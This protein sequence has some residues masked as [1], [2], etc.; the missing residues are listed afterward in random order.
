MCGRKTALFL[1]FLSIF[2]LTNV[3]I[4]FVSCSSN[5]DHSSEHLIDVPFHYQ[6]IEY[7]CGPAALQMVFDYYGEA[8]N[9][10]EIADVAR[11]IG[12]PV[13]STFTDELRRAAH[14]SNVST[15]M[16]VEIPEENIT[17]YT[18]RKLGYA[19]FEA[20]DMNLTQL[21]SFI[22][23]DK[24]LILLMWYSSY[25][26]SIHYRVATGYN[27]TH[28]FLHDPWNKLSWGGTYG[29]PNIA[30]NNTQFLD[31]WSYY[32]YW[33]LYV[34]PWT[35]NISAPEFIKLDSPF[36]INT[37]ITYP[38]SLPNTLSGYS[39]SSCN[40][41][42]TLP[43]NLS[44]APDETQRKTV[45]T[46][47]LEA[48]SNAT[49]SWMLTANSSITNTVIV[50]V[51]GMI[52]GSVWAHVNYSAYDYYDRI[53]VAI[54]ITI[55]LKEDSNSPLIGTPSRVPE[56]DVSPDQEA[57]VLVNVT[58]VESGVE[59]VTLFYNLNDSV[60]WTPLSMDFNSTSS[61]YEATIPKQPAGTWVK[62][63]I[64]AYDKVGNFEEQNNNNDYFI[65]KVVPE[66]TS[67]TIILFLVIL[68]MIAAALSR[69]LSKTKLT[70]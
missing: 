43:A 63:E 53:G 26:V 29:G 28:V 22:E 67:I 39:A 50:E 2:L 62:Y 30:F 44:L 3:G 18:L 57:K 56:G 46:G 61:F 6:D 7:Y 15:S 55:E 31:L 5:S 9:Q 24:P 20:H 68:S 25:H 21:K 11:T 49:I 16:G 36:Q 42:I 59:N 45:A 10:S 54:N 41:T 35:I 1:V 14:F 64:I 17:G 8:I 70:D 48:G 60:L 34:S 33:T 66:F 4:K 32:G 52:S 27:E 19:A 38:Q 12:E 51:E 65:Y 13:Y 40:A 47:F 23:Q 69:I 58:D 37:T